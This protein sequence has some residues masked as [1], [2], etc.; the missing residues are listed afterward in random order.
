MN[1]PPSANANPPTHTT[2]RVPKRSS[3]PGP[4]G[5]G[6][7]RAGGGEGGGGG[8]RVGGATSSGGSTDGAGGCEAVGGDGDADGGGASVATVGGSRYSSSLSTRA[9]R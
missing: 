2:H 1:M 9:S 3:R 8:A 4:A 5:A 6:A 7:E